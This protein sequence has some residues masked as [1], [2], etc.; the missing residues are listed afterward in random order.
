MAYHVY[1]VKKSH[2]ASPPL[3]FLKKK[4]LPDGN[5]DVFLNAKKSKLNKNE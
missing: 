2:N 1:H 4:K 5:L 3:F